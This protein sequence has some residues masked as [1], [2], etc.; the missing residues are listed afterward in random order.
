LGS[1]VEPDVNCKKQMSSGEISTGASAS[2]SLGARE[3]S[4]S[5]AAASIFMSI[6]WVTLGQRGRAS[7][8]C[9]SCCSVVTIAAEPAAFVMCATLST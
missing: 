9:G 1:D 3:S 8:T 4:P 2:R 7:R 6:S 5:A